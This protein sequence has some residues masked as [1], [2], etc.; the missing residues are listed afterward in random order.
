MPL[1]RNYDTG[2]LRLVRPVWRWIQGGWPDDAR[3]IPQRAALQQVLGEEQLRGACLNAGCGEGLFAGFLESFPAVTRIVHMDLGQ[4]QIAE[5]LSDP[6][7]E[8]CSGSVTDIPF[9]TGT[10]VSVLC[11]EVMEH[12]AD[13]RRGF[14]ELGRVTA[15]GGLLLISVPTP[16]APPDP[17]HVRE[18][19]TLAEVR[20]HLEESGFEVLRS[21]TCFYV[22][23]RATMA[24]WRWQHRVLGSNRRSLMPR[25]ALL[26]AG[27]LDRSLPL[28]RPWDLVV[29]AR[30]TATTPPTAVG[31]GRA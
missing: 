27:Y 9:A 11:T 23:L 28:G 20:R 15:P 17:A 8:D 5:H 4:P 10:F 21:R 24:I 13:D 25:A 18:G 7:H 14:A 3:V 19:Y 22:T 16:P 2:S 31:S 6:R 26:L 30:R 12:V 1:P 29:L